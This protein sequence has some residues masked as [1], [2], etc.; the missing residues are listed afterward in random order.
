MSNLT[1]IFYGENGKAAQEMAAKLRA[2]KKGVNIRHAKFFS[3]EKEA[4]EKVIVLADTSDNEMRR[5]AE[6]YG[7]KVEGRPAPELKPK[8]EPTPK[9]QDDQE[10]SILRAQ[11]E[12]RVGKKPFMGWDADTLRA[13]IAEAV[14]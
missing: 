14:E 7:D 1:L 2:E 12:A 9:P 10:K 11:Y 8:I 4:C 5:I 3:G 13:K 6:V